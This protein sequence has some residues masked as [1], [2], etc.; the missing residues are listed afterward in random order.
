M[1][2]LLKARNSLRY[3]V[4]RSFI[5]WNLLSLLSMVRPPR[6][7]QFLS[8]FF[9]FST[10]CNFVAAF[11]SRCSLRRVAHLVAHGLVTQ[12]RFCSFVWRDH[13]R[14]TR[15]LRRETRAEKL[16]GEQS[17]AE[18]APRSEAQTRHALRSREAMTTAPPPRLERTRSE[19][20]LGAGSLHVTR[21]QC[22]LQLRISSSL[23]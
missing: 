3:S 18:P 5:R 2:L 23:R 14:T 16:L 1:S 19:A 13:T 20:S 7:N 12:W 9:S 17:L 21:C 22:S 11:C 10:R 6:F 15:H 8:G 4:F